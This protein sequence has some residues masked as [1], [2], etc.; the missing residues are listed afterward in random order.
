MPDCLA[1]CRPTRERHQDTGQTLPD[2]Q[3]LPAMYTPCTVAPTA[4]AWALG[5]EQTDRP[6][7]ATIMGVTYP[8][9]LS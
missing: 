7:V 9:P 8:S 5:K 3:P 2:H 4:P 6:V 1:P